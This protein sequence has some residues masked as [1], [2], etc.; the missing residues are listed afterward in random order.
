M[1]LFCRYPAILTDAKSQEGESTFYK[2]RNKD[3]S[4]IDRPQTIAEQF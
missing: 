3:D 4:R 1:N 2:R